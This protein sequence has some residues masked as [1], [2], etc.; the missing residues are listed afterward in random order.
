MYL[1]DKTKSEVILMPSPSAET[2][3]SLL[4]NTLSM[5]KDL[6]ILITNF[7]SAD[8]LGTRQ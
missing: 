3:L 2:F 6:S 5:L 8:G 1:F 7:V 4:K